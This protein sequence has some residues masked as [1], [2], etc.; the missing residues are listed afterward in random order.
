MKFIRFLVYLF[1]SFFE[2]DCANRAAALAYT[3]LLSIVPLIMVTFWILSWFPTLAGT[4]EI[5][6]DFIVNNFV[7]HSAQ[8]ISDQLNQFLARTKILSVSSLLALAVVGILMIYDMVGAF[9]SIWKIKM[10]RH[11]ALSLSFYSVV[12]L[13]APIFLGIFIVFIS[14]VAALPFMTDIVFLEKPLAR[15]LPYAVAFL[16]FTFFNWIL[17]HC[18]VPFR[19]AALAGLITTIMFEIGKFCFGLY[20]SYFTSYQII[21]GALAIIPIFLLWIY[22]SWVIILIGALVCHTM[23][24]GI[25]NQQAG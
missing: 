18:T 2:N 17:P 14:Y 11:F 10:K 21:Y 20:M 12:L 6:Q 5:L 24:R 16:I 25:P 22:I 13:L 15:F 9:N 1:R 23:T 4:G 19:Y 3:T 7:A 8:V